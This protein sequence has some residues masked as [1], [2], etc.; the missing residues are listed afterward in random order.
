MIVA[1][2]ADLHLDERA[3]HESLAEQV[4]RLVWVGEDARDSGASLML[5]AGDVFERAS[6]P[7]ERNAAI[8]VFVRWASLFPVVV[9]YGNHDRPGDLDYLGVLSTDYPI[10]VLDRPDIIKPT[11][12]HC[13]VACLPW[14]RKSWLAG[15]VDAGTD[16]SELATA[17]MRV[18][19][20]GF[21][22]NLGEPE[23]RFGPAVLLGHLEIGSALTDSGQPMAG[24]AEAVLSEQDLRMVGADYYALGHI[25]KRQIL[26]GDIVYAGS[27]RQTTFGEDPGKGYTLADFDS[28]SYPEVLHKVAPGRDL[29]TVVAVWDGGD[30][31]VDVGE[32]G[33]KQAREG[34]AIRIVYEC[35]ESNRQDAQAQAEQ[36]REVLLKAG[37]R[38]VKLDPK[39]KATH[40]VRS[41][42]IRE[43][44]T[45]EDRLRALW[46]ARGS[47][48]ERADPILAKLGTLEAADEGP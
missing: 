33:I 48:P 18:I 3:P 31:V 22:A 35:D 9:V 30:L 41:E 7:A 19:L 17:A 6:T 28:P 36:A 25:H 42:A 13:Q 15:R 29:H 37:A 21:A 32:Y 45:H 1:H 40:R 16:L 14:P 46:D 47:T 39:V 12:L 4:D 2:T 26:D 8:L 10:Y 11:N 20:T 5:C 23:S 44:K 24:I 43:A 38:S 34:T 27:P